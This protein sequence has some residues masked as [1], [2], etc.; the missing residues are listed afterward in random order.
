MLNLNGLVWEENT[1]SLIIFFQYFGK[2]SYILQVTLL[3]KMSG[4]QISE[5][6]DKFVYD[7]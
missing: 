6:L 7:D 4:F 5:L 3:E 1:E 2:V